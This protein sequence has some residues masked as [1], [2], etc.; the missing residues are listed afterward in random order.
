MTNDQAL[1]LAADNVL[2]SLANNGPVNSWDLDELGIRLGATW[3]VSQH[4]N[5][6]LYLVTL[7]VARMARTPL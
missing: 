2:R 6:A 5:P 4:H 3:P 1:G 7:L